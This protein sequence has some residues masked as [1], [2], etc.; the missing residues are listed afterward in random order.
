MCNCKKKVL[1]FHKL[2]LQY[3]WSKLYKKFKLS[4]EN[5]LIFITL[6]IAKL[7]SRLP[8][9]VRK[10]KKSFREIVEFVW[11]WTA[12]TYI[13]KW[14]RHRQEGFYIFILSSRLVMKIAWWRHRQKGNYCLVQTDTSRNLLYI[15]NVPIKQ[16][17][18]RNIQKWRCFNLLQRTMSS[19]IDKD[20][21]GKVMDCIWILA[22]NFI[23]IY[24]KLWFN[25]R[26]QIPINH[27]CL[28]TRKKKQFRRV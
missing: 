23:S 12:F 8:L 27:R 20:D 11:Y 24:N 9:M 28:S 4:F 22:N 26:I 1:C 13:E 17:F 6:E 2:I 19:V 14:W 21:G 15:L 25:I 18:Y 16:T 10:S 7:S 5:E 3:N